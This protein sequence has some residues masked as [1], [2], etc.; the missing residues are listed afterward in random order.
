M[1]KMVVIMTL[2][3][4]MG[5]L[6][7]QASDGVRLS[8]DFTGPAYEGT[9]RLTVAPVPWDLSNLNT[10]LE[11]TYTTVEGGDILHH[12]TV[13]GSANLAW[14]LPGQYGANKAPVTNRHYTYED[15][16]NPWNPNAANVGYTFEMKMQVLDVVG[17]YGTPEDPYFGFG[18]YLGE[19]NEGHGLYDLEIFENGIKNNGLWLYQGDLTNAMHTLRILRYAG[20]KT[21]NPLATPYVELYVDGAKAYTG[22]ILVGAAYDQDFFYLGGL[23]GPVRADVKIDYIR[24]DFTGAYVVPEP[25]TLSLLAMGL[26]LVWRRRK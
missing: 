23:A 2:A 8:A 13:G 15:A 9:T 5:V 11:T 16:S 7:V 14:Y 10:A 3:L 19:G 26:G 24:T 12:N 17:A 6:P 4:V 21:V 18:L 1:R 20:D 25:A 22:D